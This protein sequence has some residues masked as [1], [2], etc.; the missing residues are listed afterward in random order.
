[1]GW[2]RC[3]LGFSLLQSAIAC[4]CSARSSIGHFYR[5]PPSMDLIQVE[6]N[7]VT[8]TNEVKFLI[9]P[10]H[11]VSQM[12]IILNFQVHLVMT[13]ILIDLM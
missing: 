8:I 10:N 11:R 2:L 7:L 3:S 5:A 6:S 9:Q 4:V 12:M 1:M 13:G